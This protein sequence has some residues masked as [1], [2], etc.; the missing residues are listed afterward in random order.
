[1]VSILLYLDTLTPTE[2]LEEFQAIL[3]HLSPSFSKHGFISTVHYLSNTILQHGYLYHFLLTENQ[4]EERELVRKTVH[5][6]TDVLG[7]SEGCLEEEWL[8]KEKLLLVTNDHEKR[9]NELGLLKEQ[10]MTEGQIK[11]EGLYEGMMDRFENEDQLHQTV[12]AIVK[13]RVSQLYFSYIYLPS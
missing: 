8:R 4:E 5:P 6:S 7:L 13:V 11:L 9:K 3:H 10:V 1:M 2:L 12:D